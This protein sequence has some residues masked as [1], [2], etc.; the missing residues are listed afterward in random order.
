VEHSA[1]V[2]LRHNRRSLSHV[3][4]V[5]IEAYKQRT[6][7]TTQQ[8]LNFRT[9]L[10]I[11]ISFG[12]SPRQVANSAQSGRV[13]CVR[14]AANRQCY[15]TCGS[16]KTLYGMQSHIHDRHSAFQ[17]CYKS[18]CVVHLPIAASTWPRCGCPRVVATVSR[19]A[20]GNISCSRDTIESLRTDASACHAV[21]PQPWRIGT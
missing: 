20:D 16:Q 19:F 2:I 12:A 1:A 9:Q 6:K 10:I 13:H 7:S 15:D 21:Q 4:K 11:T 8:K 3:P 14:H 18:G 17:R 5:C